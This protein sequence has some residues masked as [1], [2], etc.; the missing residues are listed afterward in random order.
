MTSPCPPISAKELAI[1]VGELMLL[2]QETADFH[3][4]RHGHIAKALRG[5][6]E[7]LGR[8]HRRLTSADRRYVVA[9]V[10]AGNVGKSTLLNAVLGCRA[11]PS[12]NGPCTAAPIEFQWGDALTVKAH[13]RQ[14]IERP[15][16]RCSNEDELG[17]RLANLADD[18]GA[19]ASQSLEKV[20]VTLPSEVLRH[21]LVIA[22][23]PGFGAAQS[24]EAPSAH[25][26]ALRDYLKHASQVF[27]VV[28]A[29]QGIGRRENSFFQQSLGHVCDDVVVT[30]SEDWD[31]EDRRKFRKRFA[32]EIGGL[33]PRMH[34]VSGR[35]GLRAR[36]E[37][38]AARLKSAG[39]TQLE[40]HLVLLA[41]TAKR[42]ELL[43]QRTLQLS[44]DVGEWLE[45]QHDERG[46]PLATRWRP[47][48]WWRWVGVLPDDEFKRQAT[49]ALRAEN[50]A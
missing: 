46:R 47:D 12:R 15:V 20:V 36:A 22:D 2:F 41:D 21:G 28:L 50:H 8:I 29:E 31:Q 4:E 24:G 14:R 38:D 23:T 25:E 10:G 37:G 11:A 30:G 33:P 5:V 40:D 7:S 19:E 35:D 13:H 49:I 6:V 48:S 34:F 45:D 44:V 32:I 39:I 18:S 1:L 17:Q 26:E 43:A 27:A 42:F 9:F 16:W 3:R